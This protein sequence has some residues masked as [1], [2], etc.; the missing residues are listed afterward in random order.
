MWQRKLLSP[1]RRCG[2]VRHARE[3]Y[4]VPERHACRLLG[5][6]RG[7]QRYEV[8]YR[9]DEDALTREIVALASRS[10]ASEQFPIRAAVGLQQYSSGSQVRSDEVSAGSLHEFSLSKLYIGG[11]LS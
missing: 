1:E 7:T 6:W 9:S 11:R 4:Q 10:G 8:I 5:Q 3:N 2:A